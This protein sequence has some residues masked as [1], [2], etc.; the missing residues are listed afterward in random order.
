MRLR[1]TFAAENPVFVPWSYQHYLQGL[2]Y[3]R[4]IDHNPAL[5]EF[6]HEKGISDGKRSFRMFTFSKLFPRRARAVERGLVMEPPIKWWVSTPVNFLAEA[7]ASQLLGNPIVHV[8]P[9]RLEVSEAAVELGLRE[10]EEQFF[11]T[12]SPIVVSEGITRE[13]GRLVK[14][15]LS[16]DEEKFWSNLEE[17]LR[18]KAKAIG[19]DCAHEP[20]H[21]EPI[22]EWRSRLLHV[23]GAHVKSYEGRF[24]ARGPHSLLA[25]GYEVGFGER[26]AQGFGMVSVP[27]RPRRDRMPRIRRR[28]CG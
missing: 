5:D 4:M 2:A 20:V 26:N 9:A 15:Y 7:F 24:R 1:I 17:N 16:P 12:I 25:L 28:R 8:G 11:E 13:D 10:R 18:R 6:L 19:L 21:F 14:H 23:Q 22:G 27:P 3:E